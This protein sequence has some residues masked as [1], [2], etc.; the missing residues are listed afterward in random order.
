MEDHWNTIDLGEIDSIVRMESKTRLRISNRVIPTLSFKSWITRILSCLATSEKSLEGKIDTELGILKYLGLNGFKFRF[1]RF[2]FNKFVV[3]LI[4]RNRFF[5]G[6]P[7]IFSK[8][9]S[10]VIDP[11]SKLQDIIQFGSLEFCR[12]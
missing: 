10:F 12:V 8:V 1:L 3:G 2:P 6:F 9:K 5:F 4:Q 11:T 7:G